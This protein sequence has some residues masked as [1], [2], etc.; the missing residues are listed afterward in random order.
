M[1][2]AT[3]PSCFDPFGTVRISST[4]QPL[5]L[6]SVFHLST[7]PLHRPKLLCQPIP[8]TLNQS[9]SI[10]APRYRFSRSTH[11]APGTERRQNELR[12]GRR[13]LLSRGGGGG[14]NALKNIMNHTT[15]LEFIN[16]NNRILQRE[17]EC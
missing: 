16:N 17:L 14:A 7:S 15:E 13:V 12:Y 1:L 6:D 3:L 2:G 5:S 10:L 9:R 11:M 4:I 8:L